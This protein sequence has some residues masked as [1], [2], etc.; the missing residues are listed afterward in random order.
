MD[1]II[2]LC[3]IFLIST[4]TFDVTGEWQKL[5]DVNKNQLGE[6]TCRNVTS[7]V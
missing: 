6:Q 4:E 1:F 3:L 5:A 7:L 2:N